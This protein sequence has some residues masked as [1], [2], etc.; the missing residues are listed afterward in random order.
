VTLESNWRTSAGVFTNLFGYRRLD[1]G[2]SA[3]IDARPVPGFNAFNVLKQHQVSDELRFSGQIFD[4]LVIT[5][6]LYYFNQ[7]FFY[8]ERRVLAGG[9]IDSTMG[10]RSTDGICWTRSPTASTRR[11]RPRSAAVRSAR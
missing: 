11:F 1:Q 4:R 2:A 6:G 8:L 5:A 3:D 10:A 9:A 7:P